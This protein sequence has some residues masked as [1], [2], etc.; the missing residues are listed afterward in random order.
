MDTLFSSIA[1]WIK[2]GPEAARSLG[3]WLWRHFGFH[4]TLW[5]HILF[6]ALSGIL[7]GQATK[8]ILI[9]PYRQLL[10][11]IEQ[12]GIVGLAGL[13][14][15]YSFTIAVVNLVKFLKGRDED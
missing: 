9:E 4:V 14:V 10:E 3:R 15:I 2:A 11:Q 1:G 6:I 12:V 8:P 7:V 5:L 13:S